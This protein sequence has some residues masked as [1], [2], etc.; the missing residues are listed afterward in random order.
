[1]IYALFHMSIL[2]TDPPDR[3]QLMLAQLTPDL[4]VRWTSTDHGRGASRAGWE[5]FAAAIPRT[6]PLRWGGRDGDTHYE[7]SLERSIRQPLYAEALRWWLIEEKGLLLEEFEDP[8]AQA[9]ADA[10]DAWRAAWA[11]STYEGI[12][13]RFKPGTRPPNAAVLAAAAEDKGRSDALKAWIAAIGPE[14]HEAQVMPT[15]K[16]RRED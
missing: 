5:E 6:L 1:M 15:K 3:W 14:R 10:Y 4:K 12:Q 13:A 9:L 8:E 16:H 11:Q 2:E 7:T